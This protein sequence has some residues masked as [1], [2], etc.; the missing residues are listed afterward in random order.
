[1][2]SIDF[3]TTINRKTGTEQYT[4]N[5]YI[6][7][8]REYQLGKLPPV[9]HYYTNEDTG[10]TTEIKVCKFCLNS[11]PEI[12]EKGH[13]RIFCDSNNDCPNLYWKIQELIAKKKEQEPDIELIIWQPEKIES[14]YWAKDGTFYP[15]KYR[16]PER[17]NMKIVRKG[18]PDKE[19]WE[20]L[21]T[22][23]RTSK[24]DV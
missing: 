24:K 14:E 17:I 20:P 9:T 4:Q 5:F 15:P 13:D 18:K 23:K 12:L 10:K 3:S 6:N 19:D 16:V 2:K 7:E 8:N 1:M 11:L 22:R 21:S